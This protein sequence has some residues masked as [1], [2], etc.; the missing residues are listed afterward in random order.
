MKGLSTWSLRTTDVTRAGRFK[1]WSDAIVWNRKLPWVPTNDPSV[2]SPKPTDCSHLG[3]TCKLRHVLKYPRWDYVVGAGWHIW[4]DCGVHWNNRNSFQGAFN[5]SFV[6]FA[7]SRVLFRVPGQA[8]TRLECQAYR[9]VAVKATADIFL[10]VHP[11]T[12]RSEHAAPHCV[13]HRRLGVVPVGEASI[14]IAVSSP[15]LEE[16]LAACK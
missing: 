9:K 2:L 14:I 4:C 8:V 15:H 7:P 1:L 13:V 5:N 6:F 12:T 3:T 16:A 10:S 11:N